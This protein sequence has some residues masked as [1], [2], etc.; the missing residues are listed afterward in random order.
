[1]RSIHSFVPYRGFVLRVAATVFAVLL[2][3]CGDFVPPAVQPGSPRTD[4]PWRQMTDAELA[5]KI[6]EA[7]G[8]VFIGFKDVDAA[9]GVDEAGRV[10]ASASAVAAAKTE[11]HRLGVEIE[12]E[13]IDMP[14]VVA[15][16][17]AGMP[18]TLLGQLRRNPLIEYIEPILPGVRWG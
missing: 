10:L 7:G 11:L 14:S 3:A 12:S 1:M 16:M 13:F 6:A 5:G 15:R 18:I 9:A 4:T 17:P 2:S 8:R